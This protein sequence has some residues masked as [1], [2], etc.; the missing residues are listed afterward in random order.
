VLPDP[1]QIGP[2]LQSIKPDARVE[3]PQERAPVDES[4]AKAIIALA[5]A[6]AKG[7][8][9]KM[10]GL[11]AGS[12][13]S[14]LDQLVNSGEWEESTKRLE[15]VRVIFLNE[16]PAD[17]LP[18]T[19]GNV[20]FAM[21]EPAGAYILGFSAR[22]LGGNWSFQGTGATP[23]TKARASEW[24]GL[25]MDDLT[26]INPLPGS[27]NAV[28]ASAASIGSDL[29]TVLEQFL[30]L[31]LAEKIAA[32]SGTD[33]KQA[34]MA[35]GIDL[36]AAETL[37]KAGAEALGKGTKVSGAALVEA[38]DLGKLVA[39]SMGNKVN[40]DKIFELAAEILK[41]DVAAV[42]D[43]YAKE[44][45]GEGTPEPETGPGGG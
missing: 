45:A 19:E 11:L 12:S 34:A 16:T 10:Q 44:K 7:D 33:P 42:K 41:V 29:E 13:R 31:E 36:T 35:A 14:S 40:E 18:S 43:Q 15:A 2:I 17:A 3:F 21:Q 8:E 9:S 27:G 38:V 32:A 23:G 22:N 4:F 24:D 26:R 5:D 28:A 30:T 37:K 20:F 6:F 39:A 25:L 1:V